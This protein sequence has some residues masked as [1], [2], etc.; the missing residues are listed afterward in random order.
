MANY[1]E[2]RGIRNKHLKPDVVWPWDSSYNIPDTE[3]LFDTGILS[4]Y[5]TVSALDLDQVK[6]GLSSSSS[7][8]TVLKLDDGSEWSE[9]PMECIL[10]G[11]IR[12]YFYPFSKKPLKNTHLILIVN[13]DANNV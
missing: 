12:K 7:Q 13:K 1:N 10:L 2:L 4:I 9:G 5:V 8:P 11:R 6:P 3:N